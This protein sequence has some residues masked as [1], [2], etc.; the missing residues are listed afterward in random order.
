M[1]TNLECSI[2]SSLNGTKRAFTLVELM[3]VLAIMALVV[4]VAMPNFAV[5]YDAEKVRSVSRRLISCIN[6]ARQYAVNRRCITIVTFD[7]DDKEVQVL[8]PKELT[9]TD[10]EQLSEGLIVPESMA[11][12]TVGATRHRLPKELLMLLSDMPSGMS[13]DASLEDF[14]PA[15]DERFGAFK[16]PEGVEVTISEVETGSKIGRLIFYPDGTSTSGTVAIKNWRGFQ[17]TLFI[18]GVTMEVST[19]ND[20]GKRK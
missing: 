18:D 19:A 5:Y 12:L 8:V 6:Y 3:V 1:M 14:V 2:S 9:A 4:S 15:T 11:D 13:P 16:I 20:E 7:W 10:K 17:I